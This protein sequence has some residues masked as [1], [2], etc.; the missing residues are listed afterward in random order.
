L[1]DDLLL[2]KT[3]VTVLKPGRV[4]LLT[5]RRRRYLQE[6]SGVAPRSLLWKSCRAVDARLSRRVAPLAAFALAL[7]RRSIARHG[8]SVARQ[9]RNGFST[10][11][12]TAAGQSGRQFA[13]GSTQVG[14]VL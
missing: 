4:L 6:I 11:P 14:I 8:A 12:S 2:L 5:R 1:E 3:I 9:P 10:A 13:D 7:C